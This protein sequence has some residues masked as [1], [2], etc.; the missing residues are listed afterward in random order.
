MHFCI[1]VVVDEETFGGEI[2]ILLKIIVIS[3]Q[4]Y[5]NFTFKLVVIGSGVQF[6]L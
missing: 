3:I 2:E 1:E 6:Y 5:I 4:E